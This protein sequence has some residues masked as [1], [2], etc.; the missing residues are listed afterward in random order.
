MFQRFR[1][2]IEETINAALKDLKF[3]K[4]ILL[5]EPPKGMGEL[6]SSIAFE[7]AAELKISPKNVVD[8]IYKSIRIG[9][10]TLIKDVKVVNGH[11]N[12]HLDYKKT[13]RALI[14]EVKILNEDYGRGNKN[15]KI[16]LEH[17]SANPDGPLHIGHGRNSIIGDSLARVMRFVG[18]KVETQFYVNDMGKQLAVVIWGLRRLNLVEGKNDLS[19]SRVYVK[20]NKL[21][22][23]NKVA[24]KQISELI[25]EYEKGN[26]E[27]KKEFKNA[28][29]Y[30]LEGINE[31]LNRLGISH[32]RFIWES[33]FVWDSS[34][35]KVVKKL[36]RTEYFEL[37]G[38]SSLNLNKF[39][40]E[41]NLILSRSDGT[42]LYTTKDIA[43]HLWKLKYGKV[44]NIW[45][46]DHKLIGEQLK[47]VHQILDASPPEFIFYEFITLP[48]GSMSTRSGIFI[49]LDEL[50]E[51]TVKRAYI[52][53][54]KRRSEETKNF[55]LKIA[56]AVGIGAIRFNIIRIAAEKSMVFDWDEALNFE[57][58][59][60][61]FI[62]YAYARCCRI[63]EKA[64]IKDEFI[65]RNLT[66]NE[67]ELIKII[68][69][70]KE[71]VIESAE[72]RKPSIIANYAIELANAFHRFYMYDKVL[73]GKDKDFRINLVRV[74]QVILGNTLT[75]LGVEALDKM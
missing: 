75:L 46:S 38:V 8:E 29:N 20:S 65:I 41:K 67:T 74:T 58:N 68:S 19:I 10:S 31:T 69:K 55:K 62:Q 12:F 18:Y 54:D 34:V 72:S 64:E 32:D 33:T 14:K 40:I 36:L 13:V 2:E 23:D 57:R 4:E 59:G 30:C 66:I 26:D 53:V 37:D 5:V 56:E 44:I 60:S 21:L 22:K 43:Y 28:A 3:K 16:I 49:S 73:K 51:E 17:T 52:E 6:S 61:S 25:K 71:I 1:I 42:Y 15:E 70:F 45:G 7:I 24:E 35:K 39:G 48:T 50:I 27:I 47:A 63:L 9:P 11:L